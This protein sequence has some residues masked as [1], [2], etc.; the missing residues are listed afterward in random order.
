MIVFDIGK[1]RIENT[2][3]IK[4]K[5]ELQKNQPDQPISNIKTTK[6]IVSGSR[7]SESLWAQES[8]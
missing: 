6:A 1:C 7:Y 3:I 2:H 8:P 5:L 4:I